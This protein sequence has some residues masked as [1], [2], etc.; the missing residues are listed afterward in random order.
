LLV[1][2]LFV[3]IHSFAYLISPRYSYRFVRDMEEEA[4]ETY[5]SCLK[6]S[7]LPIVVNKRVMS[8][9]VMEAKPHSCNISRK[10]VG[11]SRINDHRSN[12][13]IYP[14]LTFIYLEYFRTNLT[15]FHS[16]VDKYLTNICTFSVTLTYVC[17]FD[18]DLDLLF[19][20]L[21]NNVETTQH[22]SEIA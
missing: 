22:I 6:V 8:D 21:L 3:S 4:V 7:N 18:F 16:C 20:I 2:G 15:F 14:L 19:V 12:C 11:I 10:L 1:V 5:S 17:D 9:N 13:Q